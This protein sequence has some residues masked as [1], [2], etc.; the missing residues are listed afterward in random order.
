MNFLSAIKD[1][2]EQSAHKSRRWYFHTRWIQSF[3]LH[4][5][6]ILP[7]PIWLFHA[8]TVFYW[9]VICWARFD[10]KLE[11]VNTESPPPPPFYKPPFFSISQLIKNHYSLPLLGK[12]ATLCCLRKFPLLSPKAWPILELRSMDIRNLDNPGIPSLRNKP[13]A[14]FTATSNTL[15]MPDEYL[16]QHECLASCCLEAVLLHA[17]AC[18]G[19]SA[20][21]RLHQRRKDLICL[22]HSSYSSITIL[23]HL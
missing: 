19:I 11:P 16:N 13:F 5:K 20:H 21:S 7:K 12:Q 6:S 8:I 4:L 3:D 10:C 22:P 15:T 2:P 18:S 1:I 23:A 14:L 17:E 9:H